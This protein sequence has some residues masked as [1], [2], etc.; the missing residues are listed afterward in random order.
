MA[1]SLRLL[2]DARKEELYRAHAAANPYQREPKVPDLNEDLFENENLAEPGYSW[3]NFIFGGTIELHE[4]N[5]E[6]PLLVVEWPSFLKGVEHLRIGGWKRSATL[7]I[8]PKAWVINLNTQK[9]WNN[10]GNE[11]NTALY[12]KKI[13]G[14]R[15]SH[16]L[17]G[18]DDDGN[19]SESSEGKWPTDA[20]RSQGQSKST[21]VSRIR[22]GTIIEDPSGAG[23]NELAW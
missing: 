22:P 12:I 4:H 13:V 9:F 8:V 5:P 21:R 11:D 1:S 15:K 2:G 3:E 20:Q 17:T 6:H 18:I 19:A 23:A 14:F 10:V 16:T 7:Y